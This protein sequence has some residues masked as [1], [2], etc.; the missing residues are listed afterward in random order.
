MSQHNAGSRSSSAALYKKLCFF[1]QV[2]CWHLKQDNNNK[3]PDEKALR[4]KALQYYHTYKQW[5]LVEFFTGGQS[6]DE[7]GVVRD[8]CGSHTQK[9]Y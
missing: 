1:A 8:S 6:F 7:L 5:R 3:K 2:A 9:W 4:E